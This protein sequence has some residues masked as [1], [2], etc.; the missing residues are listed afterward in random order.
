MLIK[1]S[2]ILISGAKF[3]DATVVSGLTMSGKIPV[4]V[5]PILFGLFRAAKRAKRLFRQYLVIALLGR[6]VGF[7]AI[8]IGGAQLSVRPAIFFLFVFEF[9]FF[10]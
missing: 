8:E 5:L 2:V 1:I 3:S 9:L 4:N 7:I 10:R 6:L